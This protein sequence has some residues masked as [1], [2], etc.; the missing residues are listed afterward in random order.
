MTIEETLSYFGRIHRM[1]RGERQDRTEFLLQFL[2]LPES[3]RLIE[4]LR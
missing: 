4:N 2:T 1:S 3:S